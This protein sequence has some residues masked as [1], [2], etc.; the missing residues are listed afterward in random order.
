M[1]TTIHGA[2]FE[3]PSLLEAASE[4]SEMAEFERDIELAERLQLEEAIRASQELTALDDGMDVDAVIPDTSLASESLLIQASELISEADYV[5]ASTF[6]HLEKSVNGD[7]RFEDD[8]IQNAR[9]LLNATSDLH[10]E[11]KGKGGAAAAPAGR[12]TSQGGLFSDC[13]PDGITSPTE[14]DRITVRHI[15]ASMGDNKL[16][17]VPQKLTCAQYQALPI[18]LRNKE[19]EQFQLLAQERRWKRCPACQAMVEL[20]TGCNHITCKCKKE[21]C[22]ICGGDWVQQ[23][24]CRNGCPLW[25]EQN[26]VDEENLRAGAGLRTPL[27]SLYDVADGLNVG[28]RV[29]RWMAADLDEKLCSY[30]GQTFYNLDGLVQHLQTT[31]Q[32]RVYICCG[33]IFLNGDGVIKHRQMSGDIFAH[34]E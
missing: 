13:L 15:E 17:W 16:Y 3:V 2:Q 9:T 32:H 7:D 31:M 5:K 10:T 28:F 4:L 34:Y 12:E 18:H 21:F 14:L 33:R 29:P 26:L 22:Y 24:N 1:A 23:Q 6:G 20:N 27:V 25:D 19:D 8:Q 11:P 30:C